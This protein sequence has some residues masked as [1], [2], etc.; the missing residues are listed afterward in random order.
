MHIIEKSEIDAILK[1]N[2]AYNEDLN[3]REEELMR[4]ALSG[5]NLDSMND[6]YS[7][8]E[9]TDYSFMH[10]SNEHIENLIKQKENEQTKLK[11]ELEK[12]KRNQGI[13]KRFSRL[14][15][16][17]IMNEL[18]EK[19]RLEHEKKSARNAIIMQQLEEK[20]RLIREQREQEANLR[21]TK[22]EISKMYANLSP[23]LKEKYLMQLAILT[24]NTVIEEGKHQ[25]HEL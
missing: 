2:S 1:K 13:D 11:L 22:A 17:R 20:K 15:R 18:K 25:R 8:S 10:L 19:Q 7:E 12:E 5:G 14:G 6:L 21:N 24:N 4:Q 3:K 16:I 23:E 9:G